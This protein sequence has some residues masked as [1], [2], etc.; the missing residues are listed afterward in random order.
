[1]DRPDEHE[2]LCERFVLAL[3]EAT[4]PLQQQGAADPEV[5]LEL[6]IEAAR[7]LEQHLESELATLRLEQAE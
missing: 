4:H 1:M 3:I 7:R 2:E 6:L 5:T